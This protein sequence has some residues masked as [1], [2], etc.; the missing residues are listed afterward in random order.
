MIERIKNIACFVSPHGFGHASRMCALIDGLS[1]L[2]HSLKFHICTTVPN[3]FFADSLNVD[4]EYHEIITDIG[5]VQTDPVNIDHQRSIDELNLFYPFTEIRLSQASALLHQIDAFACLCDISPLGIQ[6][7]KQSKIPAV[8]IENFT[9][10]WIYHQL[11]KY[12]PEYL[13]ISDIVK[14]LFHP[15]FHIRVQPEC[16]TFHKFNQLIGPIARNPILDRFTI[17]NTLGI[18]MDKPVIFISL[19]GV[20]YNY[21]LKLKNF[22]G[23]FHV[24]V[25]DNN[26]LDIPDRHVTV[27]SRQSGIR[28]QDILAASDLVIGKPG[29]STI[30]EIVTN[31]IPFMYVPRPGFPESKFL[32]D[33]VQKFV[34]TKS[35]T[36]KEFLNGNWVSY[37][38]DLLRST[39]RVPIKSQNVLLAESV[40]NYIISF[41]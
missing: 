34:P 40:L 24:A 9:W 5:L 29:Y 23:S 37:V 11:G 32:E 25:Y 15:A 26:R 17:R 3:W 6:A 10:D 12:Q 31:G 7:A 8:L 13:Q 27:L 38:P 21:S 36:Q 14:E 16:P 35:I 18:P 1:E 39:F 4:F 28:S 33:Y 30:S 2:H 19:G 41:K 20:D 22:D